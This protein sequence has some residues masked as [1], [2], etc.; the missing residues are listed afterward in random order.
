MTQATYDITIVGAGLSGSLIANIMGHRGFSVM[1]LDRRHSMPQIFRAEKIEPNQSDL[2]RSLGMLD[3]RRPLAPPIGEILSYR[4]GKTKKV[5][6]GE[7]YGIRY[8]DTVNEIRRSAEK[9]CDFQV[10]T[11][12]NITSRDDGSW[13]E[14]VL[15]TGECIRSKF[16]ILSFGYR[17]KLH[18]KLNFVVKENKALSSLSFG[19][20]MKLKNP[21]FFSYRGYNNHIEEGPGGIDYL[22]LFY[23]GDTLRANL[24]TQF[25]RG[26]PRIKQIKKNPKESLIAWFPMLE[27]HIGSFELTSKVEVFA[28][29]YYHIQPPLKPGI[30]VTGDSYQSVSPTTGAGL[31]KVLNEVD[32]LCRDYL[33]AWLERGHFSRNDLNQYYN[34]SQKLG[35]DHQA[36]HLWKT[37]SVH[38]KPGILNA[39][40]KRLLDLLRRRLPSRYLDFGRKI[41]RAIL[42]RR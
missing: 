29:H 16:V 7:Q 35:A 38:S 1:L 13:N 25:G 3:L 27:S 20:D 30:I 36:L 28:T 17:T 5:D 6:T 33:P 39:T 15:D 2:L 14:V 23:I 22:T 40:L 9:M 42:Q 8:H 24:F 41:K 11:V 32:V 19:F 26:E 4:D 34:H 12:C 18:R 37:Y 21:E 10:A 31:T